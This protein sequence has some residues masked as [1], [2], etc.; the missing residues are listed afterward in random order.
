MITHFLI[1]FLDA[2]TSIFRG[3]FPVTRSDWTTDSPAGHPLLYNSIAVK[4]LMLKLCYMLLP[5][6]ARNTYP[7]GGAWY[8]NVWK[9]KSANKRPSLD[10]VITR[11]FDAIV[12]STLCVLHSPIAWPIIEANFCKKKHVSAIDCRHTR[13]KKDGK[14]ST[15]EDVISSVWAWLTFVTSRKMIPWCWGGIFDILIKRSGAM[16]PFS[17]YKMVSGHNQR[18]RKLETNK[19]KEGTSVG[20][21]S[22][23]ISI[24]RIQKFRTIVE[25]VGSV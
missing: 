23:A 14:N 11:Y 3:C 16:F 4:C 22:N 19:G 12:S 17:C 2:S 1:T 6:L 5:N 7:W 24:Y 8:N 20:R 13:K 9:Q 25:E 10:S 18:C 21:R 15:L